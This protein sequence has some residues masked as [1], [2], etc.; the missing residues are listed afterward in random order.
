MTE[1]EQRVRRI[2]QALRPGE[3]ATYGEI[4]EEAGYPRA[5]R[6]VGTLLARTEGLP[7]WRVVSAG[8]R[9]VP[10]HEEAQAGRLRAEGIEVRKGRVV[11]GADDGAASGRA[12]S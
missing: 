11:S 8:G 1:F 3:V 2:I 9:L 7:W 6:A 10:G 4:A 12:S 5:A